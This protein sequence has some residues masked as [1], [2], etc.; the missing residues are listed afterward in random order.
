MD[1]NGVGGRIHALRKRCG[2]SLRQLAGKAGVSPGMVSLMERS[3]T[4]PSL[5]TLQKV[6]GAL[7]MDLA[8]FFSENHEPVSGPAFPRERMKTVHGR[9]R[10]YTILFPVRPAIAVEVLDEEI[11]PTRRRPPFE[12]LKCDVA[13]YI[14]SGAL[15]LEIRGK[16]PLSL[17]TGDAFYVPKGREHRGYAAGDKAVR[18][19]TICH[20]ARY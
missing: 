9:D 4:A 10:Q 18:L 11:L 13:G 12:T 16:Q 5:V 1:T 19:I 7:G 14:I 17:R 8:G 3:K 15:T 20:P 6:L 2:L